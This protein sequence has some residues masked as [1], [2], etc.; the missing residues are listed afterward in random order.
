M[1]GIELVPALLSV[2]LT[3]LL[4]W[5]AISDIRSR[6]ILNQTVLA[7]IV[8]FG[9]WAVVGNM[10]SIGSGLKAAGVSLLI[11]YVLYA[12]SVF[13][14]GDAKLFA[15]VALFSGLS[16]LP[17]LA[18]ATVMSGGAIAIVSLL[19]RPRRALVMLGM[20]GKGDFGRGIPYGVAIAFGGIFVQW[21]RLFH[22]ISPPTLG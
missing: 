21:G 7:V 4:T 5:A 2:L 6:K 8:L 1:T 14:A 20:R 16:Y 13:G 9:V 19:T 12:T 22:L 11:C 17:V 3:G 18:Y 10:G 15:A